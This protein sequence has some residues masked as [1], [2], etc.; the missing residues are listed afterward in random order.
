MSRL[1]ARRGGGRERVDVAPGK[2]SLQRRELAVLGPE[3]VA[4]VADAVRLIDREVVD[5]RTL[6]VRN[7]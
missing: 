1:H 2:R 4:P 5:A 7:E 6:Q 3:V